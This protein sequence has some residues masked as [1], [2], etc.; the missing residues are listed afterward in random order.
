MQSSQ[1]ARVTSVLALLCFAAGCNRASEASAANGKDARP[2]ADPGAGKGPGGSGGSSGSGGGGRPPTV[3]GP[4]DVMNVALGS[5]E[6]AIILNGDLKPIE[7]IAV[8]ARVEGDVVAVS[9]REGDRVS[10]GQVMGRFE[11]AVQEGDRASAEADVEAAKS[12]VTN[13]QWN[14]EQSA[15]LHKAG[16]IPERDLRTAQQALTASTARLAASEARLRAVTRTLDDTRIL[17]PT[18]GVV[19]ARSVEIGEH[20]QRGAVMFTVVRNDVLELAANVPARQAA[21]LKAGQ[22]VRF[23]AAGQALEGRVARVAPTINAASRTITV[24]LQVPNPRGELKG[25][26][27]ATGRV[28]TKAIDKTI[29]VP[30]SAVR[31]SATGDK[32]FVYRIVDEKVDVAPVELGVTDEQLGAQQVLSGLAVGD[33]IVVG[34]VGAL[35]RGVTVNVVSA[36]TG[37]G[38][39]A[40]SVSPGGGRPRADS[41]RR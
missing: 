13:A 2:A 18:N 12:D 39:G 27:F 4:T 14:A 1:F 25:N 15:E 23:V 8:R 41:T 16:A 3:L 21:D 19:S 31:Q 32:P 33:R 9:V 20:V 11:S 34:N 36:E 17:A 28:V 29:V 26:T 35:G 24:Y 37:G 6:A 40:R 22:L 38:A 30:I 10:R 7:E 5:I